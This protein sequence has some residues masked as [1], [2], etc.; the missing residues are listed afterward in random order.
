MAET[1]VLDRHAF[2]LTNFRNFPD[3]L[4]DSFCAQPPT[5]GLIKLYAEI[6]MNIYAKNIH[7]N[8]EEKTKLKPFSKIIAALAKK[9]RTLKAKKKIFSKKKIYSILAPV[10]LAV[11]AR[12]V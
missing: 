12:F 10:L 11:V 3:Y 9:S 5:T 1:S 4:K 7:L 8:R 6:C 2:L